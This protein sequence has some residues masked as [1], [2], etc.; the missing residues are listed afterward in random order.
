MHNLWSA[1]N[2]YADEP[3][4]AWLTE[5]AWKFGFILRYPEDKT[6]ITGITFEPWHWRFVGR[7]NAKAMRDASMCLEEY[8]SR[9]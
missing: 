7:D 6:D 4:Y 9:G 1:I 2:A 8:V 5:N 3:S